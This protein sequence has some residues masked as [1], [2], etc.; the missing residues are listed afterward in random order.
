MRSPLSRAALVT[1]VILSGCGDD[2]R[3]AGTVT[4]LAERIQRKLGQNERTS[5][6]GNVATGKLSDSCICP[7]ASFTAD[8]DATVTDAAALTK[9]AATAV[10]FGSI[11]EVRTDPNDEQASPDGRSLAVI[12]G[13]SD[14]VEL[15]AVLDETD[16]TS[17]V[18]RVSKR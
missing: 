1:L 15:E 2:E 14:G 3:A 4:T 5:D 18:V 11:H 8:V 17:I 16:S 13:R 9:A 12:S 7:I 10:G 6:V